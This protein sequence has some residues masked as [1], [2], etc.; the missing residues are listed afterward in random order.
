[1][2]AG[3]YGRAICFWTMLLVLSAPSAHAQ[4]AW[5]YQSWS[6]EDGLP[7]NS[8]HQILQTR[9][10]F[11][12]IATEGGIARFDGEHFRIFDQENTPAFTTDDT[13]CL[14]EDGRGDLWIGTSDGL[15][16]DRGGKFLRFSTRDG[17]PSA[18]ILSL[19]ASREGSIFVLTD[20]GLAQ[21]APGSNAGRFKGITGTPFSSS[22]DAIARG[23]RGDLWIATHTGIAR[24]D[25]SR[26]AVVQTV[27]VPAAWEVTGLQVAGDGDVW[28]RTNSSV[29]VL[30][31][32]RW[33]TWKTA[34]GLP[35][36]RVN[37]LLVDAHETAWVGT[38]QGLAALRADTDKPQ[39]FP[40]LGSTPILSTF[41]D[42]EGNLWV[43]TENSGLAILRPEKFGQLSGLADRVI[44][45]IVQTKDGTAWIGTRD[46]GLWRVRNGAVER[47]PGARQL[48]SQVI[49][50]LAPDGRN[51][52]WV[53]TP[54][55]LNH[56][57][58]GSVHVLTSVDGLP[59]DFIRSLLVDDRDGSLW[60]GTRRGLAH[61]QQATIHTMTRADGLRSD[62]IGALLEEPAPSGARGRALWVATLGGVSRLQDGRVTTYTAANGLAGSII[63][64]FAEDTP[65]ELWVGTR[66]G[67]L[68]EATPGGILRLHAAA[69]P[70]G[71]DS[72]LLDG[73]GSLWM[74]TRQGLV[75]A[76]VAE[77]RRCAHQTQCTVDTH[78]FG[79]V[80]GMPSEE[81]STIGH[82][83]A[84]R[85]HDGDLWFATR[86]G[87]AIVHPADLRLNTVPPP[88]VI[89]SFDVD[90]IAQ[91]AGD[92][93]NIAAGHASFSFTYAGLSYSA[94]SRVRYRFMLQGFDRTWTDA[95]TRRTAYY[96]N[97]PARHYTFRV[98]AANND[99]VWNRTGAELS[100]SITPPFYERIWFYLL[101]AVG[102][103]AAIYY[104]HY[105]RVHRLRT[106]FQAVLQERNRIAREIH[107]TLAQDLVGV[108]LQLETAVQMLSSAD[109]AG[110]AEQINQTRVLVREGL[111]DARQSIWELR[112]NTA[113]DT[114]PTRLSRLIER[115]AGT[116]IVAEISISGAYR[117]LN[118]KLESEL[119]RIAQE[120][121][122][123]VIRHAAASTVLLKLEYSTHTVTLSIDDDGAGF[124]P[125]GVQGEHY[126]VQGMRERAAAIHAELAIDSTRGQGTRVTVAA[127]AE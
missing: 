73:L 122:T 84:W 100:F 121:L 126:G 45:A 75:R 62:L 28:W 5:G 12:W 105:R 85:M 32:G 38:N 98:Q 83:P 50:S 120:A 96:T 61:L 47:P 106:Q 67:G 41:D 72:L 8:V 42:R 17:L 99:G 44:T 22:I 97:L 125:S 26:R 107:D 30:H 86:K 101:V 65:G 1:M 14:A 71:I 117:A 10:G 53:G 79:A 82:P 16:R 90:G 91:S 11:V 25:V 23:P 114:L 57:Q 80:D 24:Y 37:S 63:T 77:L 29:S 95:G 49:L 13:C 21:L 3:F 20:A 66:D 87:V 9:D 115:A 31:D 112:A 64:S 116:G 51:G 93:P 94:P 56:L 69:L 33:N 102:I 55:G 88:V 103:A 108:S 4:T 109:V 123:N 124:E 104:S 127:P 52:L 54:D 35:G 43:G 2:H 19:T 59:D 68:G 118:A 27:A 70:R 46:D 110:A 119:L 81:A 15:V 60:I 18:A 6:T 89:E 113:E 111:K 78:R 36:S 7:Q 58:G 92:A 40:R 76:P 34:E 48:A 39:L 74:G